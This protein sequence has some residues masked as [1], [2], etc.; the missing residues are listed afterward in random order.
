MLTKEM[1]FIGMRLLKYLPCSIVDR[2]VL[3]LCKLKY[4]NLSKYGI[5]TPKQGPF[6]LKQ[7]T[8]RSPTIEVGTFDR[9]KQGKIKVYICLCYSLDKLRDG[10]K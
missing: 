8:G 6:F 10:Y 7:S 2:L 5:Q 4:G 9:I 3:F 1:V